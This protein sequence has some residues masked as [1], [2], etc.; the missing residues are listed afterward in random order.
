MAAKPI[1]TKTPGI[2]RRGGRYVVRYRDELG[3]PKWESCATLDEARGRKRLREN[4]TGLAV[5]HAKGLHRDPHPDCLDCQRHAEARQGAT[6]MLHAY[7]REWIDRYR[8]TGRR[9]YREQTRD[10][11][12]RLLEHFAL[13]YFSEDMR[14]SDL[15]PKQVAEFV[16]WLAA[17]PSKRGG[18]LSDR[19]VRN[20]LKPLRSALA[21]A[22]REGLIRDNPATDVALP[23]RERIEEDKDRARPF[24]GDTM[25]VVVSLVHSDHRTMF[26]LLAA[27]GLRRSELVGLEVRHLALDGEHPLVR[28]RQRLRRQGGKGLVMGPVKSKNARHELPIPIA[29]ADRLRAHVRGRASDDLVFRSRVDT[30]LDPDNLAARVLAPAYAEAGVEWAGFHTFRHTCASR[31]FDQGRKLP[32]VSRF[33]GHHSA[34]FTLQTYVHLMDEDDLGEPLEP[35][36]AHSMHTE[37]TATDPRSLIGSGTETPD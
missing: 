22:R 6:P 21:T 34:V 3:K 29:L 17:Q 25:E 7:L 24:P 20:A 31:M 37:A 8:G 13:C 35:M 32:Q 4:Q 2:Y 19:S 9:G 36:G 15:G 23:H 27:T 14:L 28:V 12:R 10:E 11:D 1:R 26:E 5:S 30:P 16:A 33:L 18:T